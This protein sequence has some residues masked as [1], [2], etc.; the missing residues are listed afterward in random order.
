MKVRLAAQ[1]FSATV[2]AGMST[3]LNCG[4]LPID[5][6]KIINF[7]NDIDKLFDIFNSRETPNVQF[8]I[9]PLIM[10]HLS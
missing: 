8:L 5:S 3:V 4:L 9:A 2:A 7:I 6:Q 1:V 10:H